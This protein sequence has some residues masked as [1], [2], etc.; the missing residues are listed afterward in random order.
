MSPQNFIDVFLFICM[1]HCS[2]QISTFQLSEGNLTISRSIHVVENSVYDSFSWE[3][4]S[5]SNV[6]ERQ[7][8]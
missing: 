8:C 7:K 5:R 3:E 4:S 2:N 1:L 6:L